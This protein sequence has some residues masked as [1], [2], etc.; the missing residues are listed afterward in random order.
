VWAERLEN[1]GLLS[2]RGRDLLL[3]A[4]FTSSLGPKKPSI[5]WGPLASSTGVQGPGHDDD[6]PPF[7]A[8]AKNLQIM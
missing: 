8:K 4:A 2:G 3:S 1:S 7:S 5:H 6:S